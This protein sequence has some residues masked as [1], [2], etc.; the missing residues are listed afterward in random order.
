[1]KTR[2]TGGL[3]PAVQRPRRDLPGGRD[4]PARGG[5]AKCLIHAPNESV[6]PSE[7]EHIALTEA[8]FLTGYSTGRRGSPA[9]VRAA[10]ESPVR[11]GF[12]GLETAERADKHPGRKVGM[13]T[14]P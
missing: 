6:D 5:G 7:I 3:D 11:G 12:A 10:D 14:T 9:V 2:G 1:M 13:N 4:L 8:L